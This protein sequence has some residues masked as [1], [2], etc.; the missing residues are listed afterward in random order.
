MTVAKDGTERLRLPPPRQGWGNTFWSLFGLAA[1]GAILV[2]CAV[3]TAPTVL[4]DW[5]VREAARPVPNGWVTDGKCTTKIVLHI[6]DVTLNLRTSTGSVARRVN[7]VFTGA[8]AGDYSIAVM[9]DP[10]RPDLVTADLGLDR[11]WNRT[12]TLL[13]IAGAIASVILAGIVAMIRNR[14]AASRA[15][16]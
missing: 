8:H 2:A 14:Q 9:A 3:Y 7:Y 1:L 5:Q 12:L 4:S 16:Q 6:C 13:V 10:E 11:L 15:A